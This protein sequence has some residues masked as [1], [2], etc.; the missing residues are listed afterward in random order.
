ML[1]WNQSYC[2]V[3]GGEQ[4]QML[5]HVDGLARLQRQRDHLAGIV[6]ENAM[7]PGPCACVMISGRPANMRFQPPF[8]DMVV[9]LTCGSFHSSTWC[10]K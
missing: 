3:A 6:L 7:W 4:E 2:D 9:M 5:A 1:V 8:S 10:V